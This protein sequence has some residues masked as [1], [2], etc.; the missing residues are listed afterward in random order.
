MFGVTVVN[1]FHHICI[2]IKVH[3][4]AVQTSPR[5]VIFITKPHHLRPLL[6]LGQTLDSVSNCLY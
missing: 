2:L 4:T 1:A 5:E 6:L 3:L